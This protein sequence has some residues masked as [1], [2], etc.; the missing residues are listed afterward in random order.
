[1][2][3]AQA[4]NARKGKVLYCIDIMQQGTS[5]PTCCQA[6]AQPCHQILA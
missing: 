3:A 5:Q 6:E 4:T 2:A 1:M